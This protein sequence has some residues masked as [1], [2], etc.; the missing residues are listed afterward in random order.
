MVAV[1]AA[2]LVLAALG[3]LG[4]RLLLLVPLVTVA[5]AAALLLSALLAPL[6]GRL[7]RVGVPRALAALAAVLVLLAVLTGIGALVGFRVV[8]RLREL[9][10]PLA[11]S[12]DRI[13]AWLTEGPLALDVQQVASIRNQVVGALYDAAPSPV[14]GARMVLFAL[15]AL[16]LVVF[17]VFFLLADGDRMW[18]W[19]VVRVPRRRQETVDGAG[20]AAWTTL[21]RYVRGVVVVAVIDAVGIGAALLLLGVPLW[22][23]LTLLVFL[24]AFVPIVGATLTGAVAVL[25]TLV[26]EGVSD[27]LVV[28]VVV[29]VVQQLEGNV[30]QPLIMGRAVR[31]HPVVILLAVTA[32]TLL[33]GIAGAVVAVPVVAVAY[34]VAEYLRTARTVAVDDPAGPSATDPSLVAAAE[35]R[36]AHPPVDQ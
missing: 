22:L 9:T 2:V 5:T 29:L 11:A 27:A 25:V 10:G 31:L 32:A 26:T 6:A 24:G 15:T 18:A 1:G 20:Q 33:F 19:L 14:A 8:S 35:A 7:R 17:L 28:L 36:E 34:Q 4:V 21:G 16:V 30:L 3:W 13:R 23:S 12:V